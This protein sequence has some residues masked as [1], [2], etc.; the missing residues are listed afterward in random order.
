MPAAVYDN[1]F[2]SGFIL[3]YSVI[4]LGAVA[5]ALVLVLTMTGIWSIRNSADDKNSAQA[6]K[7]A[8][9]CVELALQ[10]MHDNTGFTGSG[11]SSVNGAPCSYIVISGGGNL[12][13]INATGTVG[14]LLRKVSVSTSGFSPSIQISSWQEMQ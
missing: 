8:D 6:R 10:N 5:L 2:Q 1:N 9:S 12:R 3:L 7:A 14:S 13:I 11:N 4:I